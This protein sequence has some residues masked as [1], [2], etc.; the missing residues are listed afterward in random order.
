M[1]KLFLTIFLLSLVFIRANAQT[2]P[3]SKPT[4][5]NTA[6]SSTQS[7]TAYVRPTA[8]KRFKRYFNNAVGPFALIGVGFASGIDQ[9]GKNPPEWER[10]FKGFARRFGSNLGESV[11]QE[12]V[13]YGL[14]ETFKLD[15]HFYKSRKRDFSSRFKNALLTSFTGRTTSGK[16]VFDPSRI[17][18][19]YAGSLIATNVW[20]PK[21]FDSQDGFRRGSQAI[22]F[23]VGFNFLNEF[24]FHRK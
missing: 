4:P 19:S 24:L 8:E 3:T 5:D 22:A 13:T 14:D 12:S 20:Y 2:A 17:V 11:I 23:S 15:A 16:R 18:G 1:T 10:N 6:Q 9:A 21:R 7:S